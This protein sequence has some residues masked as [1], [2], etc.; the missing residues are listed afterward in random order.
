MITSY[1]FMV[2]LSE[3]FAASHSQDLL[4]TG[5]M[6]KEGHSR[7]ASGGILFVLP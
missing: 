1:C 4:L 7:L 6:L 3:L 2:G 5:R